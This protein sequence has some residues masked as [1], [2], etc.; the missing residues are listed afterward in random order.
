[1]ITENHA[2]PLSPRGISHEKTCSTY[3]L[4]RAHFARRLRSGTAPGAHRILHPRAAIPHT[5]QNQFLAYCHIDDHPDADDHAHN[6][7]HP[8]S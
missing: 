2:V 8:S 5:K 1:M 6:Y 3:M 7:I 4:P